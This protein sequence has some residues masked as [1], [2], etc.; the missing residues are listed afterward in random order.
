MSTDSATGAD[1]SEPEQTIT[2]TAE[3]DGWVACDEETGVASQGESREEALEMLD[4][5]VA[6]YKG[7]IG[8]EPTEEEL[9]EIGVDPENNE[10][11]SIEDSEIFE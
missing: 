10:S 6:L 5:A 8:H 2:L 9:R 11:G 7:E 3:D 1:R 4:D